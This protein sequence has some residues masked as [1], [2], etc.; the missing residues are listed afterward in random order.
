[1]ATYNRAHFI[2]ETLQSIQNLTFTNW[3]CLIIDDGGTDNTLEIIT[4]ILNDDSRF[5]FHSRT[6]NYQKG[7]PGTRNYGLDLA[8]GKYIIFFD[9]DDI[10][11]PDNLKIAIA[12]IESNNIDFCH[13]QKQSFQNIRPD[14]ATTQ[15]IVEGNINKDAIEKVITQEIGL[16]SCTVL[17][18]KECFANIRFNESLMYAEEWECYIR[19]ISE[20]FKGVIIS[21]VLYYNRKHSNSNTA[22]FY[23]NS[24]IRRESFTKAILLVTQ[25]L[26]EK[27]LLTAALKRYFI[28]LSI[29]FT[30]CNLFEK[31][32]KILDLPTFEKIKWK[33]FYVTLPLRLYVYRIKKKGLK[34]I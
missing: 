5:S 15:I 3:E 32:L 8:K 31:I 25:N 28:T 4:P 29:E 7:L 14:M 23:T 33:L 1:M 13:Y 27:R 22:E 30:E 10:V 2:A 9:D 6:A 26:K 20:N 34:K 11:H 19:I 16:A 21:N 17:W 18:K 12:V 24:P